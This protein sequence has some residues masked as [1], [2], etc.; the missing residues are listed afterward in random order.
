[1]QQTQYACEQCDALVEIDVLEEGQVALCP[2]CNHLILD[3]KHNPINRTI[4]LSIAGLMLFLPA[5]GYPLMSLQVLSVEN[6]ASI[7]AG[8]QALWQ[9]E[10]Y[11]VSVLVFL[12]C[13]LTP[14]VKLLSALV[15]SLGVKYRQTKRPWFNHFMV[16]YHYVDSW[17][18]LEVFL[19][20]ILVSVFKLKDLA[21]LHYD[22]GLVCFVAVMLCVISLKVT[23]DKQLI[24][25]KVA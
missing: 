5:I 24:W 11:F 20:G 9:S 22:S 6:A 23:L 4:G 21:E 14:F 1:M 2:R 3:R 10:L 18:M 7:L 12:F 25:D 15:V 16:Y 19:I 8:I 17:E 13:V